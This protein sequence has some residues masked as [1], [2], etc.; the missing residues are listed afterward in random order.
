MQLLLEALFYRM[1]SITLSLSSN[2][3][4]H[5]NSS[6]ILQRKGAMDI[7]QLLTSKLGC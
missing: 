1:H 4:H 5:E 3:S 2:N 6:L 7:L